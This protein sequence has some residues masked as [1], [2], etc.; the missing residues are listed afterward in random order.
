MTITGDPK[1]SSKVGLRD[2][3]R[4]F[5]VTTRT[6]R[7]EDL[8]MYQQ[9]QME[10]PPRAGFHEITCIHLVSCMVLPR[11]NIES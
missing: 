8:V 7:T 4:E 9:L 11:S 3:I 6:G 2:A 1:V 5:L 10:G